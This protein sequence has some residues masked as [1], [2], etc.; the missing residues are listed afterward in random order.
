[1]SKPYKGRITDV[2]KIP[3]GDLG[4]GYVLGC[5]F[6]DHPQFRG[7]RGHT[8]YIVYDGSEFPRHRNDGYEV[9]TRNSSYTVVPR[10]TVEKELGTRP[11][12]KF[13]SLR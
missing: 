4:L 10:E 5:T 12:Q 3:C 11:V 8:S 1:M 2:V 9:E 6:V 13:S 7:E